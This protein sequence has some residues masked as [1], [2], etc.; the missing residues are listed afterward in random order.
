MATPRRAVEAA[1]RLDGARILIVEG[2]FYDDLNDELLAGARAAVEA[3]GASCEVVTVP[4]ALEVP[5]AILVALDDAEAA[6]KPFD[7]AVA[8]GCVVRGETYHF[9]IV[10]GESSRA[11]MDLTVSRKLP[12]GNGILTVENDEQ[13]WARARVTDGN[14][15]GGAVEAALALLRLK[16][17]SW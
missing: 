6:G 8:L 13:A 11:L 10:A 9:E 5:T 16:R 2:R 7:A 4:G 1:E 3:V 17:R 12:L 15:G 14:K